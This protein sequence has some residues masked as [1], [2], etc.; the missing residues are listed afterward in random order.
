[1]VDIEVLRRKVPDIDTLSMNNYR[2]LGIFPV[3]LLEQVPDNIYKKER[4]KLLNIPITITRKYLRLM[5][6]YRD[7]VLCGIEGN[8]IALE[9][10]GSGWHLNVYSYSDGMHKLMTKDHIIPLSKGGLDSL[11]NLQVLC[12]HCNGGKDNKIGGELVKYVFERI[13]KPMSNERKN[14]LMSFLEEIGCPKEKIDQL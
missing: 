14:R 6:K 13:K 2:R 7:C 12:I 11:C 1:M 3:S 9:S 5:K 10:N 4:I 8:Y